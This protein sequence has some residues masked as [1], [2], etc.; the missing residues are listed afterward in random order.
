MSQLKQRALDAAAFDESAVSR[1]AKELAFN[2][3]SYR[4][5]ELVKWHHE[6]ILPL[7]TAMA[8]ELE[9]ARE[10]LARF[11][12]YAANIEKNHPEEC[13]HGCGYSLLGQLAQQI[14]TDG[15][16]ADERLTAFSDSLQPKDSK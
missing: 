12:N 1:K 9:A 4:P 3:L 6:Q 5:L 11:T 13:H 16:Y 10:T 2:S 8:D 15:Y 14:S 7:I